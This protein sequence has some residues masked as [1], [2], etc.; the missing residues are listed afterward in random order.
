MSRKNLFFYNGEGIFNKNQIVFNS[1]KKV[2]FYENDSA[3]FL[4]NISNIEIQSIEENKIE[5]KIGPNVVFH[6]KNRKIVVNSVDED[7][8]IEIIG[9]DEKLKECMSMVNAQE[10]NGLINYI[11]ENAPNIFH[12][13]NLD[14]LTLCQLKEIREVL[15]DLANC[16]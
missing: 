6:T 3:L 11:V 15:D 9:T 13:E 14:Q 10:S 8:S 2:M 5:I 12:K 7:I 16:Y 1:A 4:E